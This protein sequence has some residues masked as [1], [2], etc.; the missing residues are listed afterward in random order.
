V[1]TIIALMTIITLNFAQAAIPIVRSEVINTVGEQYQ[2]TY[3]ITPSDFTRHDLSYFEIM[4]CPN[5]IGTDF[6]SN[7]KFDVEIKRGS[8]K[9]DNLSPISGNM[10]KMPI[11]LWFSFTTPNSPTNGVA[12]F[13]AATNIWFTSTQVPSCVPE[14][15]TGVFLTLGFINILF[16]RNR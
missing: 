16:R 11:E 5:T 3:R 6:Q 14:P 15:L 8:I 7:V 4:W 2:Y 10:N 12:S 1:K 9:F 13:K